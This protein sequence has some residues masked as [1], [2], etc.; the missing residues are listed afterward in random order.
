[1]NFEIPEVGTLP[2]NSVWTE[3]YIA[4][5]SAVWRQIYIKRPYQWELVPV[6]H[7]KKLLASRSGARFR[8]NFIIGWLC[9]IYT[10]TFLPARRG[11]RFAQNL[12]THKKWRQ[13]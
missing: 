12:L 7:T 13:I 2:G 4:Y 1:M 10:R 3:T 6:L 8:E 9:Q 5:L 11:A